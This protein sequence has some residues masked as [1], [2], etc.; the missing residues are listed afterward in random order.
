[1]RSRQN[2]YDIAAE[3][4]KSLETGKNLKRLVYSKKPTVDERGASI[5]KNV[6]HV[7]DEVADWF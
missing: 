3:Q 5:K 6:T 2:P 4:L 7:E 1:M